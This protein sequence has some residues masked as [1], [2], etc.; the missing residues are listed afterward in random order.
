MP[1]FDSLAIPSFESGRAD[2][3]AG[4]RRDSR[5]RAFPALVPGLIAGLLAALAAPPHAA[6][7]PS[8]AGPPAV[9]ARAT[10]QA[11]GAAR[12]SAPEAKAGRQASEDVA[13]WLAEKTRTHR[14]AMPI[15]A[16]L[17]YRDGLIA[18]ESGDLD[19]ATRLIRGAAELDPMFAAPHL[20]LGSWLL[21][22]EPGQALLHLGS[23]IEQTSRSF[24]LQY[25][26][27]SGLF[28][29][30]M[31]SLFL[32]LLLAGFVIVLLRNEELRHGAQEMFSRWLGP[33]LA[34]VWPWAFLVVPYLAGLGLAIPTLLFLG[35]LWPVL[36]ARERGVF[37]SLAA[38]LAASPWI[39]T[40][41]DRLAA[42]LRDAEG[43][44]HGV[45]ALQMEPFGGA[46]RA[47]VAELA[48]RHP[49]DGFLQ[50]GAA[51]LARQAGDFASAEAAYRATLEIWPGNDRVL[52][53]LG[54]VLVLQGKRDAAVEAYRE[55]IRENE[56]NAAA[57]YN[58][59]QLHTERFDFEAARD[60]V[61]RAS[62]LDFDLV[63][64]HQALITSDGV[65]PRVDQWLS[66]NRFW[67]SLLA[68]R[69]VTQATPF[70]VPWGGLVETSGWPAAIG[71]VLAAAI[72]L[73]AGFLFHRMR[74]VRYC[75]NCDRV[76]C[77]RCAQRRR[78]LALC[79]AC[80]AVEARAAAAEFSRVLLQDHRQ[81][82]QRPWRFAR[83]V[84]GVLLPGV[85]LLTLR[86]AWAGVGFLIVT[87]VLAGLTFGAGWPY[88]FEVGYGIGDHRVPLPVIVTAWLV[89]Y[90]VS[91]S[92]YLGEAARH[93]E[94][95]A[96]SQRAS[97]TRP[98]TPRPVINAAA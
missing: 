74:P 40:N 35:M 87:C 22:R 42:P 58:L 36:K 5:R 82:A 86:H 19:E 78:E 66:P 79:A 84:V 17:C 7:A 44:F 52:N 53:N 69:P 25:E 85:G 38:L 28:A 56:Q 51:W 57:H 29:L 21:F 12:P 15:E 26:V 60:A 3:V 37:V 95:Q 89:L 32:G 14:G 11:A 16:R 31:Q 9:S 34:H 24:V 71:A 13:F 90:A 63:K 20:A 10:P 55:A 18:R 47:E 72:G 30:L 1:D 93:D 6:A 59:G 8:A 54:N 2:R 73:I 46:R 98:S 64:S 75:S 68:H 33:G 70:M 81:K 48:R 61:G 49:D 88:A 67:I 96:S 77:R 80:A 91:I 76:V 45:H 92:S 41:V 65:L 27:L 97:R 23:F 39:A 83:T 4:A 50:F 43:P 62:A 94:R